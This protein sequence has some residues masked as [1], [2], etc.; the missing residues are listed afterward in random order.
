MTQGIDRSRLSLLLA[1]MAK[2]LRVDMSQFDTYV[3][4]TGGIRIAETAADLAI[5]SAV[6]S[7]FREEPLH[8]TL[9]SSV[10]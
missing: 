3:N 7:T 1:V 9:S 2:S 8:L 4:V 10:K 5:M 6:I